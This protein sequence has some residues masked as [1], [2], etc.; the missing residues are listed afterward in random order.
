MKALK[1]AWVLEVDGEVEGVFSSAE[2]AVGTLALNG[3]DVVVQTGV[4][5]E[6]KLTGDVPMRLRG[7]EIDRNPWGDLPALLMKARGKV[8]AE[9]D[10]LG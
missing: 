2:Q 5:G 7:F 4:L 6:I 3:R 10:G 8:R 1:V 9:G